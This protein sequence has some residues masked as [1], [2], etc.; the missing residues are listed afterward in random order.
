[1]SFYEIIE[2]LL[3][4]G[5]YE[6]VNEKFNNPENA[7]N[8]NESSWDLGALFCNY[9]HKK[10]TENEITYEWVRT[11]SLKL[12]Q[13]YGNPKELFL[14]YLENSENFLNCDLNFAFL[15][16]I[17]QTLFKRLENTNFASGSLELALR[18][19]VKYIKKAS[20]DFNQN[21]D[22]GSICALVE[23]LANF[24]DNFINISC[25]TSQNLHVTLT[26]ALVNLFDQPLATHLFFQL[27]QV[28][29]ETTPVIALYKR[30]FGQIVVLNKDI[31]KLILALENDLNV[32]SQYDEEEDDLSSQK[33]PKYI[34]KITETAVNS[35]F[36]FTLLTRSQSVS[37]DFNGFPLVYESLFLLKTFLPFSLR[38]L[39]DNKTGRGT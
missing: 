31:I 14:V 23:K 36:C 12:C 25:Q 34:Y 27:F 38:I 35:L 17:M 39:T 20:L 4:S 33:S 18:E 21:I 13:N 24:I 2:D 19:L 26:E 30:I 6:S 37:N 10:S 15:V 11:L 9:L 29:P 16:E 7:H 8:L 22:S 1:M 32:Q 3:K 5:Q 28:K